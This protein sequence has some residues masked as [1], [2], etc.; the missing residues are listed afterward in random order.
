[1]DIA[2]WLTSPWI[3]VVGLFGGVSGLVSAAWTLWLYRKGEREKAL[4]RLTLSTMNAG[5]SLQ[6]EIA[7]LP[8]DRAEPLTAVVT[9]R[10]PGVDV[11]YNAAVT[12]ISDGQGGFIVVG[13]SEVHRA[14]RLRVPLHYGRSITAASTFFLAKASPDD[15]SGKIESGRVMICVM[16]SVSR[17]VLIRTTRTISATV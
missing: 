14:R 17:K 11:I 3:S 10:T 16:R 13:P 4:A 12:K 9:S 8:S 1:M 2:K 5:D 7:F 6:V 15:A